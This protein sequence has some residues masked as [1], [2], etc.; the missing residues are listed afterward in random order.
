MSTSE[1][2]AVLLQRGCVEVLPEQELEKKLKLKRPL[3]IKAGF[4]P[5]APDLHLGHTVLLNKLRLFQEHGHQVTF[6]IGDFTGLIGDPSGKNIT[7]RPLTPEQVREN[8]LTYEAQVFKILDP[9]KTTVK[10]NS[11]WFGSMN[12]ADLIRLAGT[13]TVARMLERD[14]FNKRYITGQSIAI[15]EFLYPLIQ[16]YDSVVLKADIELGGIDQKFNLLMGRELQRHFNQEE[17]VVMMMPLLEGLDGE[18]K[19][20]KSLS[21]YIGIQESPENIFGKVMSVSDEL[22]WRYYDLLSMKSTGEI[23]KLKREVAE[24][25]NPKDAKMSLAEELVG[26]FHGMELAAQ[27]TKGFIERFQKKE[28]PSDLE[29]QT[30]KVSEAL[31]MPQLLKRIGLVNSTSEAL[32]L[33]KQGAIKVDG[34]RLID[35]DTSVSCN[36]PLIIQV[37]KHRIAKVVMTQEKK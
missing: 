16:G 11:T 37:G 13:S 9:A 31:S 28:I 1:E 6:L 4:D 10:F 20:S 12:A 18:K 34:E 19:M 2:L 29:L 25:M 23:S 24:G 30:V 26:R 27:A 3:V 36:K 35:P 33:V 5:T 21:N 8:A 22:M 15:H 17:Q 14:D 32:R 7:R